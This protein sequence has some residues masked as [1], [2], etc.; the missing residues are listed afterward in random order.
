MES[1]FESL[2]ESLSG[3]LSESLSEASKSPFEVS[4]GGEDD[5]DR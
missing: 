1:L 2:F 3:S 4:R 5:G